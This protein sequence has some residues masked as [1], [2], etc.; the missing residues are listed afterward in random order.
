MARKPGMRPALTK[1]SV[2]SKRHILIKR[3]LEYKYDQKSGKCNK[4]NLLL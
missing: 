4:E 3:S 1:L 2:Y